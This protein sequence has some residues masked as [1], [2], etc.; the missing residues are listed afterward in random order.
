M[1]PPRTKGKLSAEAQS[2]L[3][4]PR[5]CVAC[6][7]LKEVSHVNYSPK[8]RG[9]DSL[10]GWH[11][12]CRLCQGHKASSKNK[13]YNRQKLVHGK[14]TKSVI[15]TMYNSATMGRKDL[16]QSHGQALL[17]MVKE[18]HDQGHALESFELFVECIKPIISGWKEPGTIH[19]D[20]KAGLLSKHRRRLIIATRYSAKS[21]LTAVYVAWR[22]VLDPLIKILVV[23]RGSKL[24]SRMLRTVRRVIISNSPMLWHIEPTEDCLDNAEQFQC[25]QALTVVT[26]GATLTSVGLTS[27]LP[28]LRSDLTIGDDVEGTQDDTPEK[29]ADLEETLNELHMINP[30]GE[31]I[32]L[33]TYQSEFSVY[34]KLADLE[35]ASG[36]SIW[37]THRAIMFNESDVDGKLYIESRWPDMF[38]DQ[39][40]MDWRKSV[41]TRAWRLHAMLVADPS[42]LHERP[43]KIGDLPVLR[44]DPRAT[45]WGLRYERTGNK[46]DTLQR[47]SAPKGDDWYEVIHS[48]PDTAPLAET[49]LAVDPASGLAG[50][51]AIGV[52]VLGITQGGVGIIRHLEGVR[53]NDKSVSRRRVAEIGRDFGCT[54][55]VVEELENGLFGETLENEFVHVSYPLAVTKVT[56]GGQQKGRR[57]IESLAPPMGAGR[58]IICEA[59][60]PTDHGGE[61]VNQLVRISYDGRTGR[62]K[63][64]D[65]I[66]D[67]LAHAV[68][69]A[70]GSLISDVADAAS[71]ARAKSLDR[72]SRV[73]LRYGGLGVSYEDHADTKTFN[74]GGPD[75]AEALLEEDEVMIA[76]TERRERFQ[77]IVNED[78]QSGRSVDQSMVRKITTLTRQI[79]ELKHHQVF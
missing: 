64:H 60:I 3:G 24:A 22:I 12:V 45:Q 15:E 14:E 76:L 39:D 4:L 13:T 66:V 35:D 63:E 67:A 26:G 16:A 29:V 23:S 10:R 46:L 31:K 47:W 42:I 71:E 72:W 62:S 33:G 73:P 38:S 25:P 50:R 30:R 78:L 7:E 41:T 70:K 74:A 56:T 9:K 2:E 19:N 53:S 75:L 11:V 8:S 43:L 34:A 58:L 57:I 65:D 61:F 5:E 32:M 79:E 52:A 54:R 1:N 44:Y 49:I 69:A 40:G 36:E 68:S 59:I 21:T 37:E 20:I 6:G 48:G 17:D 77:N 55:C 51:D 27:N 18:L 28:G